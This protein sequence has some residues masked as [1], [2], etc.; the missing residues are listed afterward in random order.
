M[1]VSLGST[2]TIEDIT[3]EVNW[4]LVVL[5]GTVAER[6]Y[7]LCTTQLRKPLQALQI[8]GFHLVYFNNYISS[9][10]DTT[11]S[12][13]P[14]DRDIIDAVSGHAVMDDGDDETKMNTCE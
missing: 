1:R 2:N 12:E 11:V 9:D 8:T 13:V 4:Y 7:L 5:T 3:F 10:D 6:F 14:T